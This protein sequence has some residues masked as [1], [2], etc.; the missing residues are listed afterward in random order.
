MDILKKTRVV[1]D[2]P[3]PGIGFF[4][5]TTVL[6]DAEAFKYVID[7]FNEQYKDMGF[8]LIAGIEARGFIFAS[9]LA[10]K[11]NK[12]LILLRKPGKLPADTY[13]EE[14]ALEYG[15]NAI[16]MHKDAVESG[17]RV[18][19]IDDL[20]ATGG[21]LEAAC[22]IIEKADGKIVGIGLMIE[23]D[24]LNGKEKVKDYPLYSMVN[25]TE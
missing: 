15:T 21:T 2:F 20:L 7:T 6:R 3:K 16:E 19:L 12:G 10:L 1:Q 24:F 8:D 22:K 23:L 14:Y 11:M 18:L 5:I 4:D 17:E 9:A 13:K 25:V